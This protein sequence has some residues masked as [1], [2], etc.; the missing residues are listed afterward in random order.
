MH[1]ERIKSNRHIPVKNILAWVTVLSC[2][3]T[4]LLLYF[5]MFYMVKDLCT[6][7]NL[8]LGLSQTEQ[9]INC[10]LWKLTDAEI[11]T[12][13]FDRT[14]IYFHH[15]I[16][17]VLRKPTLAVQTEAALVPWEQHQ[18]LAILL[19]VLRFPFFPCLSKKQKKKKKKTHTHT[20]TQPCICI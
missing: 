7:I 18:F 5:S 4:L 3:C 8:T 20:H 2:I 6:I 10:K 16:R 13:V 11:E 12:C 17:T 14:Y 9:L 15:H 19:N 1:G